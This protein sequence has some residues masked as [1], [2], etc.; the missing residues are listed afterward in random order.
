[1]ETDYPE[2]VEVLHLVP[3]TWRTRTNTV[4]VNQKRAGGKKIVPFE[5]VGVLCAEGRPYWSRRMA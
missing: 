2:K 5:Q 4:E 1:M 3:A